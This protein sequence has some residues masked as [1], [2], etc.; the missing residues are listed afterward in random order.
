MKYS[1]YNLVISDD[2]LSAGKCLVCNTLSGGTFLVDLS[3]AESITRKDFSAFDEEKKKQFLDAGIIISD[4]SYDEARVFSYF[5]EKERFE[6][7]VLSLTILLTMSC[8]LR[9]VYCYEGAG[10]KSNES[11]SSATRDNLFDFIKTQAE[12]RRS[13]MVSLWLFGGEPLLTL[14]DNISFLDR[15]KQFCHETKREFV[16]QIVTNGILCT[17]QNLDILERYNCQYVQITLDGLKE[18]HD[19]RRIYKSGKGSFDEVLAGIKRIVARDGLN[20]PIIRIN[21]DKTNISKT[22]QLLDF[23]KQ[24]GLSICPVDFGI[25]KGSTESC[26]SYKSNCFLE[27]ELGDILYPLWKGAESRGFSVFLS[28]FKRYLYCGLYSD[29]AFTIAPNGNIYKCWD[30]VN[31]EK[32]RIARLGIGGEVIDTT[33]AYFDWM[34]RNPYNI[35]ECRNCVYLPVCGGGCVGATY[36][37]QNNYHSSGCYKIKGVFEKQVLERFKDELKKAISRI[38]KE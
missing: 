29:S 33:Y 4:D 37:D 27:E 20:N 3:V 6:N 5:Y 26:A 1:K 28:P 24:E 8:N 34:T 36:C 23:L 17:D 30:F 32:H 38:E 21:I 7:S 16:T 22:F 31:E 13:S 2:S 25:V 15:V 9:C 11:L 19:S 10:E 14:S 18:I 35:D 12:S